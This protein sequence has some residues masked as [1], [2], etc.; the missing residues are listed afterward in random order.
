MVGAQSQAKWPKSSPLMT[1]LTKN[2]HPQAK[3]FFRVHTRR[4]ATPFE[5][6]TGSI[7]HT[8]PEKFPRKATCV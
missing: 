4:L 2:L 1:S 6:F 5:S 3:N 8:G 7:E